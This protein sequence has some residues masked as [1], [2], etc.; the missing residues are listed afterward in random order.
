RSPRSRL[1]LED[2]G[3]WLDIAAS[4]QDV[5]LTTARYDDTVM[6]CRSAAEYE[7]R[8]SE[9]LAECIRFLTIF[10]FAW[11]AIEVLS[12]VF[13]W[14][15]IPKQLHGGRGRPSAIERMIYALHSAVPI[16]GYDLVLN[17]LRKELVRL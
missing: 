3:E 15:N 12:Q 11:S 1:V 8:R 14:P 17:H 16:E 13:Q 2:A 5:R 9:A 7:D 4:V 10:S 6:W